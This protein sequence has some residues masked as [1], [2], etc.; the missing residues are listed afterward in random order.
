MFFEVI[1]REPLAVCVEVYVFSVSFVIEVWPVLALDG[2][3]TCLGSLSL[4]LVRLD[5]L[6]FTNPR[7][8]REGEARKSVTGR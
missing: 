5:W 8:G 6:S 1:T 2:S 4:S 7:E 3:A